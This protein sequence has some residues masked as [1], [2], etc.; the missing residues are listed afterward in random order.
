ML[1][2]NELFFDGSIDC[3]FVD[4]YP[5][6]FFDLLSDDD[7]DRIRLIRKKVQDI[8]IT[9]F[10][11]LD[12]NDILFVDSSHVSKTA[13]DVNHIIFNILP[14]L[15]S[16]V[17]VHFHDIWYP[18]AYPRQWVYDGLAWNESFILRAFLQYN[19]AFKIR[20]FN[21]FFAHFH[22]DEFMAAMP[23]AEANPG[24]GIWLVKL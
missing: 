8:D 5:D 2:T 20:F 24:A 6:Y 14:S 12:A 13:S 11:D 15:R 10:A 18:F 3:T 9:T 16:G 17:Y 19:G 21:S 23:L 1:D 22:R 7:K 4:P